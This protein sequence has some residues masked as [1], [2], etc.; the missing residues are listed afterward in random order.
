MAVLARPN[1]G[2]LWDNCGVIRINL[3]VFDAVAGLSIDLVEADLFAI[4]RR[5]I[6]GDRASHE[7]EAQKAFQLA[8]GP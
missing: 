4:R 2:L 5:R 6:E 8:R 1:T 3:R 7:G